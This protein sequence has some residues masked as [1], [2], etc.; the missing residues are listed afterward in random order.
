MTGT[1]LVDSQCTALIPLELER[2]HL[3]EWL[4]T[5]SDADYRHCSTHR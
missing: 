5:L 2:I 1:L 4:F 3:T